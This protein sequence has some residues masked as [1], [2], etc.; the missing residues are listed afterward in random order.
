MKTA[1]IFFLSAVIAIAIATISVYNPIA[2]A[3]SSTDPARKGLD[4]ADEKIHENTHS[5]PSDL[6]QQDVNFHTGICQGG[7]STTVL[8]QLAQGCSGGL[9][10]SPSQLGSGHNGK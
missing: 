7:H 10:Q 1:E 9:I 4:I 6:S 3:Q 2:L 5:T 8:D